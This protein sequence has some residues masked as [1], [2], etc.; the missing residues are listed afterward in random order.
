MKR[1]L[2]ALTLAAATIIGTL[3]MNGTNV[4]ASVYT[5]RIAA[6]NTGT[7]TMA[8]APEE[9]TFH[10]DKETM[11]LIHGMFDPE[12]YAYVYPDV[13][14][15][16]GITD[17]YNMTDE[18]KEKLWLHFWNGGIWAGRACNA[19]FNASVYAS[20]YGDLQSAY[21]S[22]IIAYYIHY[23][24]TGKNENRDITT[25]AKAVENNVTIYNPVFAYEKGTEGLKAGTDLLALIDPSFTNVHETTNVTNPSG[26]S[27]TANTITD[28]SSSNATSDSSTSGS[29]STVTPDTPSEPS[30]PEKPA[31]PTKPDEL[32]DGKFWGLCYGEAYNALLANGISENET[33]A[34]I[35]KL[36]YKDSY[37]Y[38]MAMAPWTAKQPN[39]KLYIENCEEYKEADYEWRIAHPKW[40]MDKRNWEENND[41]PF[42]EPEPTAPSED[43]Y[44]KNYT[45]YFAD[46]KQ[47]RSEAPLLHDFC[48]E[49]N[50][51]EDVDFLY[52][53]IDS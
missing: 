8:P 41:T 51:P 21:G 26:S 15:A 6:T 30:T 53:R 32:I 34:Y 42:T 13:S 5:D 17:A 4:Y 38:F 25:V 10:T 37:E 29:E 48:P 2:V 50:G 40:E 22:D 24:T 9:V 27:S 52:G 47:W 12:F 36:D 23:A 49:Y 11:E 31:M 18:Q 43:E 7:E 28:S 1:K 14:H 39:K 19:N 16:Y 45:T 33:G 20:A 46:Y 3:G 35:N 44:L